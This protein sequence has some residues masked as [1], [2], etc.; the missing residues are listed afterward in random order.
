[1]KKITFLFLIAALLMP[2][3]VF[4]AGPITIG[5]S[6]AYLWHPF[7]AAMKSGAVKMAANLGVKLVILDANDSQL[8]ALGLQGLITQKVNG[9]LVTPINIDT[10]VPVIEKAAAAGILVVTVDRKANTGTVLAHVG[11]DE[12]EG[13]RMA[14]RYIIGRLANKGTVIELEGEAGASPAIDRNRGNVRRGNRAVEEG[15]YRI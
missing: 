2:T 7:H 1:M 8:Q 10:L 14:A 6:F 3:A 5:V 9:I 12:V 11:V 4:A 13:G 15:H